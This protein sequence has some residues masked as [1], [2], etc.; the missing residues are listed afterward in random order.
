MTELTDGMLKSRSLAANS[1]RRSPRRNAIYHAVCEAV[2][3][4]ASKRLLLLYLV[5]DDK[6]SSKSALQVLQEMY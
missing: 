6:S 2:A 1:M 5:W 3:H 4:V